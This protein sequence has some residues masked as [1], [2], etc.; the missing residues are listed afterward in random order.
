MYT[1]FSFSSIIVYCNILNIIPCA[2]QKDLVRL[3]INL[4]SFSLFFGIVSLV[5]LTIPLFILMFDSNVMRN[6]FIKS[7]LTY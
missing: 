4:M 7:V 5:V 6:R 2:T 3:S 1:F